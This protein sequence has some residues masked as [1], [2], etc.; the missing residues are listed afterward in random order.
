MPGSEGR[1][2]G[3]MDGGHGPHG[4]SIPEYRCNPESRQRL[5]FPHRS[6]SAAK[7][8]E[9]SSPDSVVPA[10]RNLGNG[11]GPGLRSRCRGGCP[12]TPRSPVPLS[13]L[14][15]VFLR[16]CP[17]SRPYCPC[18]MPLSPTRSLQGRAGRPTP[19]GPASGPR[20]PCRWAP[21]GGEALGTGTAAPAPA[22]ALA[23]SEVAAG[24]RQGAGPLP[25]AAGAPARRRRLRPPVLSGRLGA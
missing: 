18:P 17:G 2:D 7:E 8:R 24:R 15:R 25:P 23:F 12:V 13:A 1:W 14:L 11:R 16:C 19:V 9:R 3:W 6:R 5:K 21:A 20:R 4:V 22:Q 10:I